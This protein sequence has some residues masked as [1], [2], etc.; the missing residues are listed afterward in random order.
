MKNLKKL[1]TAVLAAAMVLSVAGC[2]SSNT[3]SAPDGSSSAAGG[4]SRKRENAA[5][6]AIA[7]AS[8]GQNGERRLAGG[9]GRPLQAGRHGL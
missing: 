3:P 7:M 6:A 5:C 8:F 9:A 1:I 4:A 2:G